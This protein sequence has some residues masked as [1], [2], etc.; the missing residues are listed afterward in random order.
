LHRATQN[1]AAEY[2]TFRKTESLTYAFLEL[3]N[4]QYNEKEALSSVTMSCAFCRAAKKT[5]GDVQSWKWSLKW[6]GSTSNFQDHF[7]E[8]HPKLWKA[9]TLEDIAVKDPQLA[10]AEKLA[11][12]GT[13]TLDLWVGKVRTYH[14][15]HLKIR[16]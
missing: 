10:A 13:A 3:S 11:S 4:H 7:L 14:T 15:N 2:P 9:A 6:K 5:G 16:D 8:A 1:C 12:S